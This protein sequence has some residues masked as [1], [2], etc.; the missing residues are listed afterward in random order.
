M[1]KKSLR[2]PTLTVGELCRAIAEG[3]V[4]AT[5]HNNEWYQVSAR[6]V[7]RLINHQQLAPIYIDTRF[8][9]PLKS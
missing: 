6:E 3:R 5:L 1:E 7:R 4:P 2:Q 9:Q 8:T